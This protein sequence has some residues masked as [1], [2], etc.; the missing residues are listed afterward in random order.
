VLPS[1]FKNL[2]TMMIYLLGGLAVMNGQMSIGTMI[3]FTA[4]MDNFQEPVKD[5][6]D[7][8]SD[9]QELDGDLKR[10][11]DVLAAPLD[12]E[13]AEQP[14]EAKEDWPLQLSGHVALANITFGY[15]PLDPP[16]FANIDLEVAPG[17]WVAFVGGSGSGKTTLANLICGLYRSWEGEVL[18]DNHPRITVPRPV[19]IN[20][21]ATVS[22]E[23]F[24]F[25]GTVREN[26]TLW[27]DTIPN[28]T[29]YKACR[30]AAIFDVVQGLPGGLEGHLLEG[31]ANLSGGQRQRVEI[32]RALVHNPTILVLDEATSALDAETESLII[33]RLR[34]RGITCIVV[35]HRLSTIRDCDEIVV[36]DRGQIVQRG[37]H[38]EL[39]Q[40]EGLYADLLK[41]GGE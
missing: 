1:L 27:D 41:A 33:E 13:V 8:G 22:Q 11:D 14:D 25:Q 29:L 24:L 21:F 26:L 20:S 5:L 10:L 32:A 6:V 36:L 9:I 17:K 23:V 19:M 39:W 2:N 18:F 7:L 3:A 28:E 40:A 38:D 4:L 31:G 34:R 30:D 12:V 16:L 15:S 35:A 37:T